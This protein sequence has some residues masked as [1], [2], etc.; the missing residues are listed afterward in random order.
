MLY[1][2]AL[3]LLCVLARLYSCL[4]HMREVLGDAAPDDILIEAILKNKFD[5][6]KALSVVLERDN[7][8]NMKEK[9]ERAVSAGKAPKGMLSLLRALLGA[10]QKVNLLSC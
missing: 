9:S 10:E 4:D 8:Q 6:Q 7:V 5:V 3:S 2:T 1:S